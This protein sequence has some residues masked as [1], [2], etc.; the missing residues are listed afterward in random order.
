MKKLLPSLI[1]LFICSIAFSQITLTSTVSNVSCFGGSNGSATVSASGGT[2]PYTYTWT[3]TNTNSQFISGLTA[4]AYTVNVKDAAANT[5]SL[6]VT[7]SEPA[8]VSTTLTTTNPT[9]EGMCN[10]TANVAFSG[11]AGT[12]TF[13]WQPGLQSGSM[14]NNLCAGNQTVT[15][16][17]NGVCT[18][19]LTFTLNEP[20]QLTAVSSATNSNCGQANGKTC[21][22]VAGGSSP[23][24]Y[25]WSNG[26]STLCNNNIVAGLYTFTVTD[27][28]GCLAN[29][30]GLVND[31]GGPIVSISSQTNVSCFGGCNGI[32]TTSTS[33]GT[34]P[35]TYNWSSG[36]VTASAT[37]LCAGSYS[38]AVTDNLGCLGTAYFNITQPTQLNAIT[39]VSHVKCYGTST[40]TIALAA[41]GGTSPYSYSWPSLSSTLSIVPNVSVGNYSAIVTDFKGCI[42]SQSVSVLQP[43][44]MTTVASVTNA[45]CGGI[46]DGAITMLVMGGSPAYSYTWAPNIGLGS[47]VY[48]LCAGIYTF[49]ARDGNN[50]S[51]SNVI[52]VLSGLNNSIPNATLASDAYNETCYLTGDGAID[53][54]ITGTNPGPFTYLWNNG[55]TNQDISNLSSNVYWVTI[56]DGA[57]N[58]TTIIDTVQSI[59]INCGSISGYI[60]I[61]NNSDCIKNSGDNYLGNNQIIVNPGNRMGYSNSNGDYVINNL[62]YGTY[63]ITSSSNSN[64]IATCTTT[65]TATLNSGMPNSLNKNFSKEYLPNTQPDLNVWAECSGIVPGFVC[66]VNYYISNYNSSNAT[67]IY[68]A[69]LPSAF[70]PNIT[71]VSPATYTLSGD[72][73]MWNFNNVASSLATYLF[74]KFVVPINTQLGS[75]FTS[76]M[77]AQPNITDLNYANNTYCYSRMVTGSFDPNDKTVSPVGIGANGDIAT[78]ET[79]L[80][81]LIRFQNTG[82][83]PAVNIVV[84]DTLSANVNVNTFEMLGASHNYNVEILPGNVLRW[85]F[86]NIMLPDSNSNE[87]GSHGYI[88]YRIKRT[89]NNTPGTQ[90][91]NT[92]YIYFDFN[93]PIMT[94][95]AINTI[96]TITGIK[97]QTA[98]DNGWNVYP[99][100]SAGILYLVNFTSL[101]ETSG[102]QVLNSIGKIVFEETIISNY[103]T[104]DLSKLNT[105]VYFVKITSD[106][107][108]SVKRIVLSK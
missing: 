92:A 103:K 18:T 28:N 80:T 91:K 24:N 29:A 9:C 27:A 6:V 16:T 44:Q 33:G 19:S 59:G 40:G 74:V 73:L 20:A 7:I 8:P 23:L 2:G 100:P 47:M 72:T 42:T 52:N 21:A 78:S 99:N 71:L 48:N 82:N 105:G 77:R 61:D 30:A 93:D 97:Y 102:I 45:S 11:G 1:L 104:I 108:T 10:G 54:T 55:A 87:P 67:G 107:N 56:T 96:E 32:A 57:A 3:P 76:C 62:P 41:S 25:L 65:E 89:T 85:K 14:V 79:D 35:Y 46:C 106:K 43:Q 81:Y 37:N 86:N 98:G 75:T 90:I 83:G 84:K 94:N 12:T 64:I 50:C 5:S 15:I 26:V 53:I 60:F 63:T 13:L 101:K 49:Q 4:E 38:V 58:C 68:K 95:T 66:T 39:N 34:P 51:V 17:S 22:T 36:Q 70:I 69:T 31:A 88:Q